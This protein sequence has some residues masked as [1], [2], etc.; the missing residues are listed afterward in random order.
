MWLRVTFDP[1]AEFRCLGVSEPSAGPVRFQGDMFLR[2]KDAE[3]VQSVRTGP[4]PGPGGRRVAVPP[5]ADDG[6]SASL[7]MFPQIQTWTSGRITPSTSTTS[8]I[9]WRKKV[10]AN[11]FAIFIFQ[12]LHEAFLYFEEKVQMV[13]LVGAWSPDFWVRTRPPDLLL[14]VL[15]QNPQPDPST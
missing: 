3:R 9:K 6:S 10:S 11:C 8:T 14:T 1:A 13:N 7:L 5:G 4:T 2:S 12:H 15:S